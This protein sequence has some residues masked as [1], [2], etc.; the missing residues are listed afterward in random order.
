MRAGRPARTVLAL[1][2]LALAAGP[3]RAAGDAGSEP[4]LLSPRFDL[5]IWSIVVFGVLFWVLRR[6]AWKPLLEGL[7]KREHGIQAAI[8]EAHR[9]K[10]EAQAL[11]EQFR[12][13]MDQAEA[14]ARSIMDEAH[15]RG[16]A[17]TED[18][19]AK[20]RAENQTERDRLRREIDLAR[21]NALKDLT[22]QAAHLSTMISA[23]VIRRNLSPD[24]HRRLVDEAVAEIKTAAHKRTT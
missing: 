5:T 19:V 22:E 20:A 14:R 4:N 2:L 15:K 7:Q 17:T 13:E 3:L 6:F 12:L 10:S 9:A 8:D 16:Q 23:K 21:D 18:M 11:R 1:G 24:D